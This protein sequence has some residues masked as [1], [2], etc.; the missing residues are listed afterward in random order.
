MSA[1]GCTRPDL[2]PEGSES[3]MSG[4][5][6]LTINDNAIPATVRET[7]YKPHNGSRIKDVNHPDFNQQ[8]RIAIIPF[9]FTDLP[10]NSAVT[11]DIIESSY[12]GLDNGSFRDYFLENSYGQYSLQSAGISSVVDLPYTMFPWNDATI[13]RDICQ[14]SNLD[15]ALIDI[16]G[17]HK[18][19]SNEVQIVVIYAY[20]GSGINRSA[21]FSI[22]TSTGT[23][24]ISHTFAVIDV[25]RNDDP[26]KAI[27][28]ILY[29]TASVHELCHALFGLSDRYGV[30]GICGK[31]FTG[32]YDIMSNSCSWVHMT[33]YDK[34]KIGW[35][36][37]KILE[38]PRLRDGGVRKC[39]AFSSSESSPAALVLWSSA[40]PDEFFVI[41]NRNRE[42]S[43]YEFD[44]GL[45]EDGLAVWWAS[46]AS[47]EIRLIDYSDWNKP[48][49]EVNYD[50]FSGSGALFKYD[51]R[52]PATEPILLLNN[53]RGHMF[54][55]RALSPAGSTMYVEL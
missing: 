19:T 52:Y 45:P 11:T 20:G 51:G 4:Q 53:D 28:P 38:Q 33:A 3:C 46:T 17:D 9:A 34:M 47:D 8:G 48:P 1:T 54:I 35:I 15:W 6:V 18:I 40:N 49:S 37:P 42:A 41:E 26:Q 21:S 31:G 10:W 25:K 5:S 27:N 16:N 43:R 22:S 30:T 14:A 24:E 39:F 36:T 55:I 44:N 50:D 13:Y 32:P 23:Y 29:N 12:F 2:A 7:I